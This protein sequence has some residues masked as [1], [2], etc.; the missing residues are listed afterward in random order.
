MKLGGNKE[1]DP[2]PRSGFNRY[3]WLLLNP[4]WVQI[5]SLVSSP[6]FIGGD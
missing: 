5:Q 4:F 6:N 2:E 3:I 1:N